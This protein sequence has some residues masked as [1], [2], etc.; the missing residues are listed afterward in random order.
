MYFLIVRN[1]GDER[2]IDRNADDVY[3]DGM[4]FNCT[5]SLEYIKKKFIREVMITCNENPGES[6]PAGVFSD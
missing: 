2:C 6:F 1:L 4:S 5:L 3:K